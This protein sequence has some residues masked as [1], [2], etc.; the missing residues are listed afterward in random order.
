MF[1][2]NDLASK[3]SSTISEIMSLSSA[4]SHTSAPLPIHMRY[5]KDGCGYDFSSSYRY[6]IPSQESQ[7]TTAA[8]FTRG[9]YEKDARGVKLNS[10]GFQ[11]TQGA[12][13]SSL[14]SRRPSIVGDDGC[15]RNPYDVGQRVRSLG[16]WAELR[17]SMN[18]R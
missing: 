17:E 5:A 11:V 15:F 10:S 16:Y 4:S 2:K 8:H 7:S 1:S 18:R 12:N 3:A 14:E 9:V 13:A 6:G